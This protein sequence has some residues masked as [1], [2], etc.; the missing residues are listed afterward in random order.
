MIKFFK[1]KDIVISPFTIARTQTLN[2]II[3]EFILATSNDQTFPI[4]SRVGVCNNNTGSCEE[5]IV[6][7]YISTNASDDINFRIGKY[8]PSSSVFNTNDDV[9]L[10]GTYQRQIYNTIKKMHYNDYN[11]AYNI[12]GFETYNTTDAYLNLPNE[13]SEITLKTSQAGDKIRPKS[14]NLNNQVGD[15]VANVIDDGK[16]NL[17]LSGTY[18]T[19]KYI[20]LSDSNDLTTP[21]DLCGL[22]SYLLYTGSNNL[23]GNNILDQ[24]CVIPTPT[25]TVTPTPSLTNTP[26]NTVTPSNTLTPSITPTQTPSNSNTPSNTNTPSFTPSQTITP[27]ETPT[28]TI[29]PSETPTQSE[30]PSYTPSNTVTPTLSET[31]TPNVTPSP[32]Y[33]PTATCDPETLFNSG[34]SIYSA[35]GGGAGPKEFLFSTYNDDCAGCPSPGAWYIIEYYNSAPST[36]K[37]QPSVYKLMYILK[38]TKVILINNLINTNPAIDILGVEIKFLPAVGEENIYCVEATPAPTPVVTN[39]PTPS[40]TPTPSESEPLGPGLSE[41]PS[42]SPTPTLTPTP[43]P[44][45][46]LQDLRAYYSFDYGPDGAAGTDSHIYNLDL[47][48]YLEEDPA[49]DP[50]FYAGKSGSTKPT[51]DSFSAEEDEVLVEAS[52]LAG[53]AQSLTSSF[54]FG[55][56]SYTVSFWVYWP[57]GAELNTSDLNDYKSANQFIWMLEDSVTNLG[58]NFLKQGYFALEAQPEPLDVFSPSPSESTFGMKFKFWHH[59]KLG[60]NANDDFVYNSDFITNPIVSETWYHVVSRYDSPSNIMNLTI[61]SENGSYVYTKS[62]PGQG[63]GMNANR[64]GDGKTTFTIGG[65][66]MMSYSLD[67]GNPSSP[68]VIHY[69]GEQARDSKEGARIDELAV[70]Y[71]YLSDTEVQQLYNNGEGLYYDDF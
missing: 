41:T 12:F 43:T 37:T 61:N 46:L 22:G 45:S 25:P 65:S 7:S 62:G 1:N 11:N 20:L 52:W 64:T 3:D 59:S 26:T 51:S 67:P 8:K 34:T 9:N 16:H 68:G 18:F 56:K 55:N 57:A 30:T 42:P 40:F 31:Q 32:T 49:G 53:G 4:I 44:A 5:I 50:V 21:M 66:T 13:F 2:S 6:E 47:S 17:I 71:R 27:S 29:T 14:I 70:W 54:D 28:Q 39:T 38:D 60:L 69:T 48:P 35:Y 10:D 24:C 63:A 15:I 19:N 33:T 58:V 36:V 23:E